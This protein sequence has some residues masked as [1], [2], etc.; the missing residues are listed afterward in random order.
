MQGID[1]REGEGWRKTYKTK[2][3]KKRTQK[4]NTRG[5]NWKWGSF[6]RLRKLPGRIAICVIS[7]VTDASGEG[8]Q[9][10]QLKRKVQS[11]RRNHHRHHQHNH[12]HH[13]HHQKCKGNGLL[14]S[15]GPL[16]M[17]CTSLLHSRPQAMSLVQLS[18]VITVTVKAKKF[19]SDTLKAWLRVGH[20][21][22]NV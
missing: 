4:N 6:Q 20:T 5:E 21:G 8:G 7:R 1:E 22:R 17:V 19:L 13:H 3:K 11:H 9:V 2:N 15:S 12:H 16:T 14:R 10:S 18:Q